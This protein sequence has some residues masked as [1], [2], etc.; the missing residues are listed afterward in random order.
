[1]HKVVNGVRV[2]LTPEEVAAFEAEQPSESVRARQL[3]DSEIAAIEA[4]NPFT[5]R[6]LREGLYAQ[7]IAAQLFN[8]MADSVEAEIRSMPGHEAFTIQRMPNIASNFGMVRIKAAD[9]AIR[10]KRARRP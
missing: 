2:E 4:A 10:A 8:Q 7:A 6:A 1:M 9:D 3:I 5:H